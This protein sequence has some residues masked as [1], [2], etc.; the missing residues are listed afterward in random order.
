M[1][2]LFQRRHQDG[3]IKPSPTERLITALE[4]EKRRAADF[5]NAQLAKLSP[6][7]QRRLLL[8]IGLA[9][10]AVCVGLIVQAYNGGHDV[11][12]AMHP[13]R[14]IQPDVSN[15]LSPGAEDRQLLLEF[16]LMMDSL[17]KSP[18]GKEI[19]EEIKRERPGLLDTVNMLLKL[20][21]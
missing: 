17:Q 11:L 13:G 8:T 10:T 5:L 1:K 7:N 19:Y 4:K 16:Q 18:Y 3:K 6:R 14:I 20:R 15:N 21:K 2:N 9:I 12:K